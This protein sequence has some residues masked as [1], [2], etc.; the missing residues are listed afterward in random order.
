MPS[1]PETRRFLRA[2]A[3]R[4]LVSNRHACSVV[5][6]MTATTRRPACGP[7]NHLSPLSKQ[8]PRSLEGRGHPDGHAV[9][10]G[11]ADDSEPVW[12]GPTQGVE[13]RAREI[14]ATD[15]SLVGFGIAAQESSRLRLAQKSA[16]PVS[17]SGTNSSLT[18]LKPAVMSQPR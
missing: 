3:G 9:T 13:D 8:I 12:V 15:A 6:S 5:R 16:C 14:L 2:W 1:S 7:K 10:V 18:I 11:P 17:P 4:L